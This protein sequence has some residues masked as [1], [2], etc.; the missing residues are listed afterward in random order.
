MIYLSRESI[1]FVLKTPLC[2]ESI[3]PSF[4]LILKYLANSWNKK[5]YNLQSQPQ[6]LR[7]ILQFYTA[8]TKG[9]YI[10]LVPVTFRI[11]LPVL[12]SPTSCTPLAPLFSRAPAPAPP[13]QLSKTFMLIY[14]ATLNRYF[15]HKLFRLVYKVYWYYYN[16]VTTCVLV[17]TQTYLGLLLIY[18]LKWTIF[19]I[20]FYCT[21]CG[22]QRVHTSNFEI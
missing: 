4:S 2:S 19:P 6:L 7:Y 12:F 11:L 22:S 1:Q 5:D 3:W 21:L 10:F 16:Y 9:T 13:P 8:L 20:A 15:S 17:P 18:L 14:S